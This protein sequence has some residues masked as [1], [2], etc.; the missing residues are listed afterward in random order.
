MLAAPDM[1]RP[2]QSQFDWSGSGC[3]LKTRIQPTSNHLICAVN[4][5]NP[6]ATAPV[7]DASTVRWRFEGQS[8]PALGLMWNLLA[9]LAMTAPFPGLHKQF[10]E[11]LLA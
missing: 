5:R 6:A 3:E 2:D 7:Q 1:L 4:H 11:L 10:R 8:W 9:M